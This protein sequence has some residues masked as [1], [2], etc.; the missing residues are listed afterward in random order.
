MYTGSVISSEPRV[1]RT[2]SLTPANRSADENL[3]K[4]TV[5]AFMQRELWPPEESEEFA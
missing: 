5:D 4:T 3:L 1:F 2:S